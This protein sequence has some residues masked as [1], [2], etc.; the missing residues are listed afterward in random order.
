MMRLIDTA[1]NTVNFKVLTRVLDG[2][3]SEAVAPDRAHI[4]YQ[5]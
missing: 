3:R 4:K 5:T 2:Q 1:V